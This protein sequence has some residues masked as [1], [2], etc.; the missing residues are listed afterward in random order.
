MPTHLR[1]LEVLQL[2]PLHDAVAN[3]IGGGEEPATAAALLVGDGAGLELQC[4][5]EDVLIFYLGR[6]RCEDRAEVGLGEDGA[7]QLDLGVGAS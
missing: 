6:T 1:E 3:D 4:V 2:Q 5:V 7:C